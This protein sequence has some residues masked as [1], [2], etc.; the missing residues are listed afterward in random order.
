MGALFMRRAF[1]E[2][3]LGRDLGQRPDGRGRSVAVGFRGLAPLAPTLGSAFARLGLRI[4]GTLPAIGRRRS[5]I[6]EESALGRVS[7][8]V[9]L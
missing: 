4:V 3:P 7:L 5:M 1:L 6:V 2:R 9:S 8:G